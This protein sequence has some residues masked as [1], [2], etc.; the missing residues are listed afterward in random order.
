MHG[1]LR[2]GRNMDCRRLR[3]ENAT[4]CELSCAL[5]LDAED[6]YAAQDVGPLN[7]KPVP[8]PDPRSN[9]RDLG[10]VHGGPNVEPS[11]LQT[12]AA[13]FAFMQACC[14][15]LRAFL[16]VGP[17]RSP[18]PDAHAALA[19]IRL[20]AALTDIAHRMPDRA[21]YRAD[22]DRPFFLRSI[23]VSPKV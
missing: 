16:P 17:I 18:T 11:I 13:L 4:R 14:I 22:R 6:D 10:C 8:W 9:L 5:G 21:A 20:A 2:I 1:P 12:Q 23:H 19:P 3:S 15:A 7:I